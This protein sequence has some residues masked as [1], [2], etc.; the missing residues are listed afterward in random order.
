MFNT[1]T[2]GDGTDDGEDDTV[3]TDYSRVA[4]FGCVC[5]DGFFGDA[6]D[7]T[8]S[9]AVAPTQGIDGSGDDTSGDGSGDSIGGDGSSGGGDDG[10]AND[11]S[12]DG[13]G[14]GSG[15]D[16]SGDGYGDGSNRGSSG[17]SSDSGSVG[18]STVPPT[19]SPTPSSRFGGSN[20]STSDLET[21]NAE[22]HI[23]DAKRADS[24]QSFIAEPGGAQPARVAAV[25][26]T[27]VVAVGVVASAL[28]WRR[29]RRP[30]DV[31]LEWFED[32]MV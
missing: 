14:D 5:A 10:G 16:I 13:S 9:T 8:D 19:P 30:A 31:D 22:F 20:P 21:A 27:I 17:G 18:S 2:H 11:I 23:D 29:R 3:N 28:H 7:T 1:E 15:D 24:R 26:G 25:I 12:D 6:C 32:I 4:D